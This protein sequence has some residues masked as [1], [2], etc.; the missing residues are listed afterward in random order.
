[1]ANSGGV[2]ISSLTSRQEPEAPRIRSGAGSSQ[3]LSLLLEKSRCRV[4]LKEKQ[5]FFVAAAS[6]SAR[7]CHRMALWCN[8]MSN[9]AFAFFVIT[10][11]A[12]SVALAAVLIFSL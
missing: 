3:P 5:F 11:G 1:M 2:L 10:L 12:V 4:F 8:V 6:T 9:G 7:N